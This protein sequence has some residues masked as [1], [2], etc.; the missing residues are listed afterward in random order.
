MLVHYSLFL[1][2]W[3]YRH[4]CRRFVGLNIT[5]SKANS[6]SR[7]LCSAAWNERKM[8]VPSGVFKHTAVK[9]ILELPQCKD[10]AIPEIS[11][12]KC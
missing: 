10:G 8:G 1:P 5:N 12:S 3:R 11:G 2:R 4:I 9:R 7:R 6:S